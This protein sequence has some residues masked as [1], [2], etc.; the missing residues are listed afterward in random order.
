MP[1]VDIVIDVAG[2]AAGVPGEAREFAYSKIDPTPPLVTLSLDDDTGVTEYLWEL[3]SQPIGASAV[4]SSTTV[5]SPT[6]TPTAG[7]SGS[8]LV[9]CTV[10]GDEEYNENGLAFF[11]EYLGL[12]KPAVGETTHFNTTRGWQETVANLADEVDT[13][14][15]GTVD[16][17]IRRR[18]VIDYANCNN[19]PPSTGTGDRYILDFSGAIN[20]GWGAGLTSGDIVEYDGAAW[21]PATPQEGWV[22]YVDDQD[23]DYRF[24]D[25]GSPAWEPV[26]S[27][28]TD[29][30]AIHDN[31][32]AE[33]NAVTEKAVPVI[34]D[35]MLIEDSEASNAKKKVEL[36]NLPEQFVATGF[37]GN[38]SSS[39]TTLQGV[40]DEYDRAATEKVWPGNLA[41]SLMKIGGV[42]G[43][44]QDIFSCPIFGKISGTTQ[45]YTHLS[46]EGSIEDGYMSIPRGAL[47]TAT[48]R[49]CAVRSG[50]VYGS[51]CAGVW[52]IGFTVYN[53]QGHVSILESSYDVRF[54]SSGMGGISV[55]VGDSGIYREYFVIE[56]SAAAPGASRDVCFQGSLRAQLVNVSHM[57][58]P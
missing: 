25:D 32:A 56:A 39:K 28:G 51:P 15:A 50:D 9:A 38:I 14:G 43:Q 30:E 6:F 27:A 33:I 17:G 23:T 16:S 18:A 13:I 42:R 12:R 22:A 3:L 29:D 53:D 20:P 52:D 57:S 19:A 34:A 36:G 4:L 8:Y 40:L 31:V 54:A 11:T 44:A 41:N 35:L 26:V 49:I 55:R 46:P 58:T 37:A 2:E 1:T 5:A 45:S 21:I 10:N 48:A 7:K 24:V 47:I